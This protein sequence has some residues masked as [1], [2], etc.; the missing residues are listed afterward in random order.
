[1]T[2]VPSEMVPIS[3]IEPFTLKSVVCVMD[4]NGFWFPLSSVPPS[5]FTSLIIPSIVERTVEFSICLFN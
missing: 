5:L 3:L 1:M 2:L 4:T